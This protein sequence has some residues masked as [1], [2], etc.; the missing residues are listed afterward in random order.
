MKTAAEDSK[1][2]K[3]ETD[4]PAPVD[5]TIRKLDGS[6]EQSLARE[7]KKGYDLLFVG[8][9]HTRAKNGG[10]HPDVTRIASAFDGPLAV[11]AGKG[12][13]LKQPEQS[14]L[15]I[16]VP[17]N[18]TEVSRR[19]AEV[20]IAIARACDC[21]I[22]ALY[23]ANTGG[24]SAGTPKRRGFRARQQEQAIIKEIVEMADRYDV[25]IKTACTPTWRRT[26]PSSRKQRRSST[27]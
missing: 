5:V 4:A 26:R 9:G 27:T 22:S 18:G 24:G 19:A 15:H 6:S 1:R 3:A 12:V 2:A 13:H 16:L 17:V 25:P 11:V 10:F 20:A 23:V 7:A 8:I 14:P 21:P